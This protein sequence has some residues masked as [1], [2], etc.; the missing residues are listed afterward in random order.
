MKAG[1][2]GAGKV[3]CSFGIYL[4]R[5]GIDLVGYYSRSIKSATEAAAL[6]GSGVY[7][8]YASLLGDCDVVFITT[9]DDAIKEVVRSVNSMDCDVIPVHMS[10]VLSTDVCEGRC[11]SLHP[12]VAISD[13]NASDVFEDCVFS[14]EGKNPTDT[15]LIRDLIQNIGGTVVLI[16][17]ANKT[18]YHAA[19]VLASNLVVGLYDSACE[20]L[21][22]CG[23]DETL[24][25]KALGPLFLKN[26]QTIVQKGPDAAL[27]GPVERADSGTVLGHLSVLD[28]EVLTI[29]TALSKKIL[30]IAKRK[31][32]DRN[33]QKLE[34]LL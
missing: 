8:D 23:F 19:A 1:F 15:S 6:T 33:Y 5:H 20:L 28:D 21:T 34:E 26:A 7:E 2:I 24:A 27:T 4:C 11:V 3:G 13:K 25:K 14:L 29:Y 16:D 31:N 30:Q 17:P 10:G 22:E 18:K 32:K 12:I 9:G